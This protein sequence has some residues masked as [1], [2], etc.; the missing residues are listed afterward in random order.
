MEIPRKIRWNQI[1]IPLL[2]GFALGAGFGQW[3]ARENFHRRWKHGDMKQHMMERFERELRL[4]AD[5]KQQVGAIF[6]AKY[7]Q[8]EAL[9]AEVRPKFK[10]LRDE[11]QAEIRRILNPDQQ[12]KLDEMTARREERRKQREK[13]FSL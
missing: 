10:A 1:V 12:K 13:F 9:Q 2:I 6:D 8:M 4:T 3:Y 5:Q 11:T 7:P